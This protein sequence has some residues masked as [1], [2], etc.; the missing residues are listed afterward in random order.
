MS[1]Q[2][3]VFKLL[4]SVLL[5]SRLHSSPSIAVTRVGESSKK[6]HKFVRAPPCEEIQ[7]TVVGPQVAELSMK[8]I[9]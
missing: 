7:R 5:F 1:V 9:M 3:C 8:T 4:R 2:I 6:C